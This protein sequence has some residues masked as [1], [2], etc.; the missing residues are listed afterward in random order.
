MRCARATACL[1]VFCLLGGIVLHGHWSPA[2]RQD[3]AN[4]VGKAIADFTLKD[5]S[6]RA[7]SLA[8]QG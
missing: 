7:V 8:V 5:T 6:G 4:S 3:T 2:D 1:L